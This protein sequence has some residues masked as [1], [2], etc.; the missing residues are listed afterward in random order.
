MQSPKT[1]SDLLKT[2]SSHLWK[3]KAYERTA[4]RNVEEF[5]EIVGDLP[6]SQVKTTTFDTW[7][8]HQWSL[9]SP[10]TINRKL[11]NIKQVLQFALDRD[12]MDKMP[13]VGGE[14]ESEGRIRW[15]TDTEEKQM[16]SLLESWG[17]HEAARFI[18]VSIETGMRRG[19]LLSLKPSQVDLPWIRLWITKTRKARSIPLT[20]KAQE[21]LRGFQGWSLTQGQLRTVWELLRVSM[22]LQED[23][24]FVLHSLRHTTATRLLAKT[25]DITKVQR[26]LGHSKL[27]T[28]MR[29]AHISDEDLFNA[30][31]K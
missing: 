16:F 7:K 4:F 11:V 3:G 30:V 17:E 20:E 24:D 13:K 9:V 25:G 28:T 6:L 31:C 10:A 18:R 12:W 22:G 26:L 27:A 29:Y 21:A 2:S 14:R 1:L 19:E 23:P 15:L 5:I 8:K